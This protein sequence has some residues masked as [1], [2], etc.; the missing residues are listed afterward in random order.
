MH[1]SVTPTVRSPAE[2]WK[3]GTF[4]SLALLILGGAGYYGYV[5]STPAWRPS[6]QEVLQGMAVPEGFRVSL[7]AAEPLLRNPVAF[8]VDERQRFY[9]AETSRF[10]YATLDYPDE[11]LACRTWEDSEALRLR[12]LASHPHPTGQSER[13]IR[14]EDR[15]AQGRAD[16]RTV[17]WEDFPLADGVAA[18][19]LY[20]RGHLWMGN[21][22]NLWHASL[23]PTGQPQAPRRALLHGF[24]VRHINLGHDLHGLILGPDG[25]LYFSM[26]DRGL[27]V[28]TQEGTVLA[29]PDTGAVLRCNPDGS[30]L[31]VVAVGV[32][33]SQRLAFDDHGNLWTADNDGNKGDRSRWLYLVEGGE[34]GWRVGF[35]PLPSLGPW[36]E[37]RLWDPAR[38]VPSRLPAIGLVGKG[39]S[40]VVHYP[41]TGLPAAYAGHFFLGDFPCDVQTFTVTPR[42]AGFVMTPPRRFVGPVFATD[43]CFGPDGALYLLDWGQPLYEMENRGRIYRVA[44]PATEQTPLVAQTRQLL[45]EG[46]AH[47]TGAALAELLGHPDRRVRQETQFTL[48]ERGAAALPAF[49]QALAPTRPR[50][51]RLHAIWGL[52][53]VAAG[54]LTALEPLPALLTDDD[55]EV[56]AQAV[57][58]LGEHRHLPSLAALTE[59]LRDEA[60]RVRFFAAL[61]LGKLGHAEALLPVVEM[62]RTNADQ[63]AFVR[64]AG[65]MALAGVGEVSDLTR[66]RH[67][68]SRAVRLGAL[69]A[70]R[71]RERPE[72]QLFLHDA[73]PG[74]VLEAARAI[75]DVPVPAALP[76]LAA[77]AAAPV[78]PPEIAPRVI[79]ANF[80]LGTPAAARALAFLAARPGV[81]PT[82]RAAALTALGEWSTHLTKDRL[83]GQWSPLPARDDR[84]AVAAL[85]PFLS[86][87]V[88]DPHQEVAAA[89]AR[90]ATLLQV[91]LATEELLAFLRNEEVSPSSRAETLRLLAERQDTQLAEA[92][93]AALDSPALELRQ[94]GVR[95]LARARGADGL[96][97]LRTFLA[98]HQPIPV[99]QAAIAALAD[100]PDPVAEGLLREMLQAA[101]LGQVPAALHLDLLEAVNV[102]PTPVLREAAQRLTAQR[103]GSDPLALW[104]AC[105]EGGDPVNG[106]RI[107]L[108]H[109]GVACQRCHRVEG[110]GGEVGPALDGVASRLNR[111]ALLESVVAPNAVV[112]SGYDQMTVLLGNGTL[113]VGRKVAETPDHLTLLLHD[114]QQRRLPK[115]EVQEIQKGKSAMPEG[116]EKLLS[117]RELRDLIAYLA[118]LQTP[119]R[120]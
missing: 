58:V 63:D 101:S 22:P 69:L 119:E 8:C 55:A 17:L 29:L 9:V 37:E 67:D 60:P 68:P 71:R 89:A 14:L 102:R 78:L 81:H 54:H 15:T 109:Q 30:R 7:Y 86:R 88:R 116:M 90:A 93:L 3:F 43:L 45:A 99:R 2:R 56:R 62:L 4:L 66:L 41:G 53:Q 52:G 112:T 11:H 94:Q 118:T 48:A 31:E 39:P 47:R 38:D 84:A 27:H 92:V 107:F 21:S 70:L 117:P 73:D 61:A 10:H 35:Q 1:Q 12:Q 19:V 74:V 85:R 96:A 20:R 65:V 28:R 79:N 13:L 18:G 44:H 33:N 51:G 103:P 23:S 115:Q 108:D 82:I 59:R 32:R 16:T 36:N 95:L 83:L 50:L 97:R 26:G 106:R 49:L 98:P 34:Y 72:V 40:G 76:A 80:R 24:G 64:H 110:I 87:L 77:L 105:L 6:P 111:R 104:W 91:P 57:K 114:G 5:T 25:K 120:K 75:H 100:W 46:M 42:G 113:V